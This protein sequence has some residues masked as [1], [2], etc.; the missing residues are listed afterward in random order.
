MLRGRGTR[1]ARRARKSSGSNRPLPAFFSYLLS[2]TD[3]ESAVQ[4]P[5][6]RDSGGVFRAHP[7]DCLIEISPLFTE[8]GISRSNG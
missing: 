7:A 2:S 4:S 5:A 8:N 1:A 6:W 3:Q